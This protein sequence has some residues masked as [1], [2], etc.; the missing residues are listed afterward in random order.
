MCPSE[1]I[2]WNRMN[3]NKKKKNTSEFCAERRGGEDPGKRFHTSLVVVLVIAVISTLMVIA[4]FL[5]KKTGRPL[6]TFDNPLYFNGERTQP[7]V[8][9][10]NKL[11]EN[12]EVENPEPIIT[13]W[14]TKQPNVG[15]HSIYG[16][17]SWYSIFCF[18]WVPFFG[19][20]GVCAYGGGG[21]LYAI[22]IQLFNNMCI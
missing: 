9:D 2:E 22:C 10:T 7:D 13:L 5:Y 11:I 6:P 15:G 18:D 21:C 3:S 1:S 20:V 16:W 19:W 12:A 8:V 14:F 17:T 4:F